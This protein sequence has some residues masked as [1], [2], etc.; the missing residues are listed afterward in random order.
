[1]ELDVLNVHH[2]ALARNATILPTYYKVNVIL[3][4]LSDIMD[5][6]MTV[7]NLEF[8]DLVYQIAVIVLTTLNVMA[9]KLTGS[10]ELITNVIRIVQLLPGE[11]LILGNVITALLAATNVSML[12]HVKNVRYQNFSLTTYA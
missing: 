5:T 12:T 6:S 8:V 4:V 9:V 3:N 10:E 7:K 1:M 11:I 2:L